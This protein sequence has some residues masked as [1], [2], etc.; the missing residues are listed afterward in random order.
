MEFKTNETPVDFIYQYFQSIQAEIDVFVESLI[1]TTKLKEYQMEILNS[2]REEML[3]KLNSYRKECEANFKQNKKLI[4]C[5]YLEINSIRKSLRDFLLLN[6]SV[7]YLPNKNFNE[8]N[9]RF[10]RIISVNFIFD[11]FLIK[12]VS[13]YFENSQIFL[14]NLSNQVLNFYY[15]LNELNTIL[16]KSNDLLIEIDLRSIIKKLIEFN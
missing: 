9:L 5:E 11:D 3:E 14:E 10:G 4:M 8:N 7:F 1:L 6:R 15:F 13:K 16:P 12:N 2:N